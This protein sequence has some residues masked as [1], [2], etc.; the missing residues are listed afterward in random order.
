MQNQLLGGQTPIEALNIYFS[1]LYPQFFD[2]VLRVFGAFI[3]FLVGWL[4]AL[5]VKLFVEFVLRNLKLEE[6]F[7]K[8]KIDQ[9]F[10]DFSW[11]E[12]LDKILAEVVFW[13]VF[14]VFLMV[15]FDILG[16]QIVNVFIRQALF[17]IPKAIAGGLVLVAGLL[18]GELAR[19]S[20]VGVFRGLRG[21]SAQTAAVFVKWVIVIF[22]FIAALNQW[23]IAPDIM[24][25]L[26]Q[27]V[28]I[29]LAL[30]GGLAFGLGGQD[31]AR[32]ILENLR[33]ET[34]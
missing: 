7:R 32:E 24:A 31:L 11:E 9:Y 2:A 23:G 26:I 15:A 19:K 25:I 18:F 17:Y 1:N 8:L 4:I 13:V 28:V 5:L 16:L 12:T 29:F 14:V 34:H 30:A 20:L 21:K 6:L 27:G 10:K 33:R 3:V 22:A